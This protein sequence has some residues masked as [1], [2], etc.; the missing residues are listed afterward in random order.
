MKREKEKVV[1][2]CYFILALT[3]FFH[4]LL[5]TKQ[6]I[7]SEKSNACFK[8]YISAIIN[9]YVYILIYKCIYRRKIKIKAL[10]LSESTFIPT[11][12]RKKSY[13]PVFETYFNI[14][15]ATERDFCV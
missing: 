10:V 4:F 13:I 1:C 3:S 9:T 12:V 14:T 8:K 7:S 2:T 6:R 5:E 11:Y 15:T